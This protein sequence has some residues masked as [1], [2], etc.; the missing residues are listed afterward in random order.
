MNELTIKLR[1]SNKQ[2][3][4]V[5]AFIIALYAVRNAIPFIF[6]PLLSFITI[7]TIYTIIFTENRIFTIKESL[8]TFHPFFILVAIEILA[9]VTAIPYRDK[10]DIIRYAKEFYFYI[11]YFYLINAHIRNKTDFSELIKHITKFFFWFACGISAISIYKYLYAPDVMTLHT[12]NNIQKVM[13][14]TT[15]MTDYN[16]FSLFILNAIILNIYDILSSKEKKH[17][18][19]K[20]ITLSLM[21]SV[22]IM[23]TSRRGI[24]MALGV[25]IVLIILVI[26]PKLYKKT[27]GHNTQKRSVVLLLLLSMVLSLSYFHIS[28]FQYSE[29]KIAKALHFNTRHI[30]QSNIIVGY[31]FNTIVNHNFIKIWENPDKQIKR[32]DITQDKDN[33]LKDIGDNIKPSNITKD[34]D[35]KSKNIINNNKLIESRISYWKTSVETLKDYSI[36]QLIIGRGFSYLTHFYNDIDYMASHPHFQPFAVLLMS[37]VIGLLLWLFLVGYVSFIYLKN[38]KELWLLASLFAINF[39]FGLFSNSNF[40]G[41]SFL[42]FLLIL[43]YIYK[44]IDRKENAVEQSV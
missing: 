27:F 13:Y 5:L 21:Y 40:L 23:S 14:G 31:R 16:F 37:G 7:Y 8:R 30:E 3:I 6:F 12:V 24:A 9:F 18:F 29:Q 10:I 2:K 11:C 35:N 42:L 22:V 38:I 39:F 15:L 26:I 28:Y 32:G 44:H 25:Y 41:M 36:M 19:A 34:E 43:P 20:L 1:L 17:W 33:I 4:I